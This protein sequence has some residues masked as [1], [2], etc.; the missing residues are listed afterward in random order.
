MTSC[1]PKRAPF[2]DQALPRLGRLVHCCFSNAEYETATA[3]AAATVSVL[4]QP[5]AGV[6]MRTPCS[7]ALG[8]QFPEHIVLHCFDTPT[9]DHSDCNSQQGS[10]ELRTSRAVQGRKATEPSHAS[11]AKDMSVASAIAANLT[12]KKIR[13]KQA[14][15]KAEN[16]QCTNRQ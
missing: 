3:A 6:D 1:R 14:I 7:R 5:A 9:I 12:T 8:L 10:R 15:T 13:T 2:C 11:E 4:T 16:V